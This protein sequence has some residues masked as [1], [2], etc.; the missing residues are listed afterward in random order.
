MPFGA[1]QISIRGA[2][3]ETLRNVVKHKK[4][5]DIDFYSFDLCII[6]VGTNDIDDQNLFMLKEYKE[7]IYH[8]RKC[9]HSIRIIIS[10]IVPRPCD[11]YYTAANISYINNALKS[12]CA[13]KGYLHF[14]KT[15]RGF[16]KNE[17]PDCTLYAQ[18][19]MHFNRLGH[20]KISLTIKSLVALWRQ[21]RLS[22][23]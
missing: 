18:D 4:F 3:I 22:F 7:L 11:F 5:Y 12:W 19:L 21:A 2:N 16:M 13:R 14:H 8:I 9:N 15:S 17:Q 20:I 23:W 10:D 1:R 6:H